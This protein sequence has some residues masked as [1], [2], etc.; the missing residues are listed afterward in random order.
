MSLPRPF[1]EHDGITIYHGD[2]F[3]VLTG[4]SGSS[5]KLVLAD[6]PY[7]IGAVSVG[8]PKAKCGTWADMLNSSRWFTEWFKASRRVLTPDGFLVSFGNW[9]SLPTLIHG[10]SRCDWQATNCI[11]WDKDWIGPAAPNAL[12]PVWELCLTVAMPEATVRN[13]SA[14]DL[15]RHKWMAAHSGTFTHPAE[16]PVALLKQMIETF[17][18]AGSLVVDPFAGSGSTLVAAKESCRQAIGIEIE[19]RY[20]EIAAKRLSQEVF[21]FAGTDTPAA[22]VPP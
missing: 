14:T 15:I 7:M 21:D 5:A 13:R 6:P 2:C 3:D 8:N 17:T 19:E 20:C 22:E 18:E 12:R 1:Y 4:L 11:I 16:K 9:R 10:L